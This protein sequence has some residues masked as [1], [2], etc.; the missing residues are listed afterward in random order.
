MYIN[1]FLVY[2]E[3]EST[4]IK[5]HKGAFNQIQYFV[6]FT[7]LNSTVAFKNI[8]QFQRKSVVIAYLCLK[9]VVQ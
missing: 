5:F 2:R 9:I 1:L 3:C 6:Y 8:I 7:L 4:V